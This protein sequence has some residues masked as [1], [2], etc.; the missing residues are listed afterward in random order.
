MNDK[1]ISANSFQEVLR[2]LEQYGNELEASALKPSTKL[3]YLAGAY[4][5][6][7]WMGGQVVHDARPDDIKAIL[8]GEDDR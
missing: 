3:T 5:F 4:R 2:A 1:R 6:V 7:R 8:T